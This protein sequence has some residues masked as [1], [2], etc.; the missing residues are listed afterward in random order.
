M[1]LIEYKPGAA[2]PPH[3]HPVVGLNC[4]L[5]G[6][7]ESQYEGEPLETFHA[8]DSYQDPANTKHLIFP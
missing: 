7:A 2:A 5:E 3:V 4:I 8:G 6:T 1:I